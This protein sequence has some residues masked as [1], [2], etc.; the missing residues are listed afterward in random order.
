MATRKPIDPSD[1]P[2]LV[3]QG[4][5]VTMNGASKVI[6]DGRVYTHNGS[7]VAVQEA[8]AAPPP[9]FG[10]TAVTDTGG[11]LFPGLIDLHNHLPYNV[12][13]LW[14]VPRK[15]SNRG[16]W[17]RHPEYHSKISAPMQTLAA[18]P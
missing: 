1:S 2:K 10:S 14:Q 6:A 16:Q 4:R 11:T 18:T 13:P 9:G 3:L 5:V 8:T 15:F 12:L 7:I 17:G